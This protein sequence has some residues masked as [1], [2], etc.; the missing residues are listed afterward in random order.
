MILADIDSDPSAVLTQFLLPLASFLIGLA[1]EAALIYLL[2]FL[3]TLP[4]RRN[5]R[6]RLFLDLLE[7]GLKDG[8]TPESAIISAASSNDTSL[9]IRF[10]LLAAHLQQGA[11]LS[12]AL[13]KVPRL[14]PPQIV[15]MLTAGERIGSIAKVLPACRRITGDGVS[16]VR[17]AL[18]YVLILGLVVSPAA[19]TIPVMLNVFVI[20]KF[21]EVFSGML[22]GAQLPAFTRLILESSDYILLAQAAVILA[23]WFLLFTYIGG[24][25]VYRWFHIVFRDVPDRS[26]EHTSELQ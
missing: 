7:L 16:Q 1:I 25:R 6:T 26:E 23:T 18:N 3:I 20:P 17:G 9:S 10:H 21:K 15:A 22:E 2:Y 11:R 24:P 8:Q 13:A 4:M 12:A 5:E 19:L 14:L